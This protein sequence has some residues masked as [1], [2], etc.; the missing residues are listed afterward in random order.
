M[1]VYH[2]C[3]SCPEDQN[4]L[5]T[6]KVPPPTPHLFF[7][8]GLFVYRGNLHVEPPCRENSYNRE[9]PLINEVP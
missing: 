4:V 6:A 8:G 1:P 2:F 7:K 3:A 9:S 5:H